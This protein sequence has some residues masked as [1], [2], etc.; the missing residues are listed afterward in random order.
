MLPWWGFAQAQNFFEAVSGT[1]QSGAEFV[2]I[3]LSKEL[4]AL[5]GLLFNR[6]PALH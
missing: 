4:T 5:S 1:I 6:R 2:R 3:D